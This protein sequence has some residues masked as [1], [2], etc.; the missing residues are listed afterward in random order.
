MD[1]VLHPHLRLLDPRR[2]LD[3]AADL[4]DLC[5]GSQID[6]DGR[7]YLRIVRNAHRDPLMVR[8]VRGCNETVSSPMFGYVWEENGLVVGNISLIPFF[9]SQGCY[10]LIANV[11]VHPNYRRRGIAR[12]LTQTGI[13][14][15]HEHGVDAAWLQVRTDA[16]GA[17]ELYLS[18]GFKERARRNTWSS[19]ILPDA[20][21]QPTA[22]MLKITQRRRAD[23]PQQEAWLRQTY[24]PEFTWNQPVP[25][26]RLRPSLL[27]WLAGLFE[28][29]PLANWAAR[30]DGRLL[31]LLSWEMG[32][33]S[34]QLYLAVGE[35]ERAQAIRALLNAA[36]RRLNPLR[37][38][39][40]NFPAGESETSF[41]E[42]GFTLEHTLVWMEINFTH[43]A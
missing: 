38:L 26:D 3:A 17:H 10:Y 5:F 7:E 20:A 11:A 37:P 39:T 21:P 19:V 40:L 14:H 2:D 31:G 34:D 8:W 41:Y 1:A 22:G 27:G 25:F 32:R 29:R 28:E 24:P 35:T 42:S 6:Y 43:K 9:T 18:L 16:P 15:I 30:Q 36:H 12:Q 33:H 23:W 4:I 13:R